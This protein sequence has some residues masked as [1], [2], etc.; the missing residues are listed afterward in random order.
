M[1]K[2][3]IDQLT[4]QHLFPMTLMLEYRANLLDDHLTTTISTLLKE[5]LIKQAELVKEEIPLS[6]ILNH[7]IEITDLEHWK[8]GTLTPP[9]RRIAV[10]QYIKAS[11]SNL[12]QNKELSKIHELNQFVFVNRFEAYA[13]YYPDQR[14]ILFKEQTWTYAEVN[15]RA[16]E[17]ANFLLKQKEAIELNASGEFIIGTFLPRTP[18]WIIAILAIW[19]AGGA[20]IA[21][22]PT[23][24]GNSPDAIDEYFEK[25]SQTLSD[26]KPAVI[27]THSDHQYLLPKHEQHNIRYLCLDEYE[28]QISEWSDE[29]IDIDIN[30]EELAYILYTSGSSGKPKGVEIAHRGFLPCLEAHRECVD[31]TRDS[32]MAQYATCDFDAWV[33][34]MMILGIGGTLAI[35]PSE[36][37]LD[38]KLCAQYYQKHKINVVIFT[39]AFL[40]KLGGPENFPFWRALFIVGE[41]FDWELVKKWKTEKLQ[42]V[43][44]YGLTETTICATLEN[45]DM[46]EVGKP[47]S[48]G[49]PIIGTKIIVKTPTNIDTNNLEIEKDY[50]PETTYYNAELSHSV[51][52]QAG[53]PWFGGIS[54]TRGYRGKAKN[55]NQW[56]FVEI[57]GERFY[58]S[59]DKA[60]LRADGRLEHQGR[61]S[62]M[63]KIS[64]KRIELPSIELNLCEKFQ[65]EKMQVA[66]TAV[67]N[68]VDDKNLTT[69][70]VFL[71]ENDHQK[72]QEDEIRNFIINTE[73]NIDKQTPLK[74]IW[75][76][77]FP[78]TQTKIN[79]VEL[80]KSYF[81]SVNRKLG[82]DFSTHDQISSKEMDIF[83]KLK[84]AWQEVI[85]V[86]SCRPEDDFFQIGGRSIDISPLIQAIRHTFPEIKDEVKMSLVIECKTLLS[87]TKRLYSL[88]H[89]IQLI[90]LNKKQTIDA[91]YIVFCPPSI[92]GDPEQDYSVL[93][94]QC[95]EGLKKPFFDERFQIYGLKARGLT[96]P[97]LM[98]RTLYSS[99]Q[100]YALTIKHWVIKNNKAEVPLFILGWSSGGTITPEIV[101][102]LSKYNINAYAYVIDSIAPFPFHHFNHEE[103]KLELAFLAGKLSQALGIKIDTHELR[104]ELSKIQKARDRIIHSFEY[105]MKNTKESFRNILKTAMIT[106]L[107][108]H[109]YIIYEE[110]PCIRLYT[111]SHYLLE[112]I[113]PRDKTHYWPKKCIVDPS[114]QED[115]L[116]ESDHFS[117]IHQPTLSHKIVTHI[118]E[119]FA[120]HKIKNLEKALYRN[121][122]FVAPLIE[123]IDHNNNEEENENERDILFAEAITDFFYNDQKSVLL[124]QGESGIGKSI[125]TSILEISLQRINVSCKTIILNRF[126]C[127]E[128]KNHIREELKDWPLQ[129]NEIRVLILEGYDERRGTTDFNYYV[130]NRL[131]EYQNLKVI[132]TCRSESLKQGY[133]TNFIPGE[134]DAFEEFKLQS[135][136]ESQIKALMS[137]RLKKTNKKVDISEIEKL[138]HEISSRPELLELVRNPL[139]LTFVVKSLPILM[140][141]TT[142]LTRFKIYEAFNRGYFERGEYKVKAQSG[143]D[144]DQDFQMECRLHCQKIALAFFSDGITSYEV[145]QNK[146]TS[147]LSIK[148]KASTIFDS[149]FDKSIK[150]ILK[151]SPIKNQNNLYQFTH[152]TE[153]DFFVVDA[154][155]SILKEDNANFDDFQTWFLDNKLIPEKLVRN[156]SFVKFWEDGYK[157]DPFIKTI[158]FRIIEAT[159]HSENLGKI[160]GIAMT[161]LNLASE[162]FNSANLSR[163]RAPGAILIGGYFDCTDFTA[164]DLRGVKFD[165]AWLRQTRLINCQ[166]TDVTFG[167]YPYFEYTGQLRSMIYRPDINRLITLVETTVYIWDIINRECIR[168]LNN[169]NEKH[170]WCMHLS[171]NGNKLAL[172]IDNKIKVYDLISDKFTILQGH[173]KTVWSVR[174]SEDGNMLASGSADKTV[175]VWFLL[176]N[177]KTVVMQGH[178][179]I[180]SAVRLSDDGR[181]VIS[182]SYMND[183]RS[184]DDTVRVWDVA[185]RQSKVLEANHR[186]GRGLYISGDGKIAV[187]ASFDHLIHIWNAQTGVIITTLKGHKSFVTSVALSNDLKTLVSSD[188]NTLRVWNVSSGQAKVLMRNDFGFKD[189]QLSKDELTVAASARST[190]RIWD[191]STAQEEVLR[192]HK[193]L[194]GSVDL[195]RNGQL[196]ASVG[197]NVLIED[198]IIRLWDLINNKS[199]VLNK[200][201]LSDS[202]PIYL[203]KDGRIA[204]TSARKN[205]VGVWDVSSRQQIF[206]GNH[207]DSLRALHNSSD[208]NTVVTSGGSQFGKADYSVKVWTVATG[209]VTILT[210]HEN[211]IRTVYLSGDGSVVASGSFDN[212]IRIWTVSSGKALVLRI[213]G[214]IKHILL[215]ENGKKIAAVTSKEVNENRKYTVCVWDVLTTKILYQAVADHEMVILHLNNNGKIVIATRKDER[216][217]IWDTNAQNLLGDFLF[218]SSVESISIDESFS[219]LAV[220]LR[221]STIQ[222]WDRTVQQNPEWK[223]RWSSNHPNLSLHLAD[224]DFSGSQGLSLQN[225]HLMTQR[226]AWDSIKGK[227][228]NSIEGWDKFSLIPDM[229]QKSK[230][231]ELSDDEDFSPDIAEF[232]SLNMN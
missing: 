148:K 80:Q 42:I 87:Q 35:V 195:S 216:L 105:L 102:A 27:I 162:S 31:L 141:Y 61:Y 66:V 82:F 67:G 56:R 117:I 180:V 129:S 55:Q 156:E 75:K 143:L 114:Q 38:E 186:G 218:N 103:H 154:I 83:T 3:L 57:D 70:L 198:N 88:L 172:A 131:S 147:L 140:N 119:D 189:V 101:N 152:K 123:I 48:I 73:K 226:G 39:P 84:K 76:S 60:I 203:S 72:K 2:E 193:C 127:E 212:T 138:Y 220:G 20:F 187:S 79:L 224:C 52:D 120:H 90:T 207:G 219:I 157:Q 26:A 33:A 104:S 65:L 213:D 208:R 122:N 15:A 99:A 32:I 214:S 184:Y 192:G 91:P 34:E 125:S 163:V 217:K 29:N 176:N 41:S 183:D 132:F 173:Q 160:G 69:V 109:N 14:A 113:L 171:G 177:R 231:S 19:K 174:L 8:N 150:S 45:L 59:G 16:N 196:I 28:E 121:P 225:Q 170:V 5:N 135:F 133:L 199:I 161:L 126:T 175:R 11:L 194:I 167:E 211:E 94:A 178:K 17:L 136:N 128:L 50:G 63:V 12:A 146:K 13:K 25:F 81:E 96:D 200:H 185:S 23:S 210:G 188:D 197:G 166:L 1:Y 134:R 97:S 222:V 115:T 98:P 164:S 221:D 74:I 46:D 159:R 124:L 58:K 30:P 205:T 100:D 202:L 9:K 86:E 62:R 24:I 53:E 4:K 181:T 21:I 51:F 116:I 168:E 85:S 201:R 206:L 89:P 190:V 191:I 78:T 77:E 230:K 169:E 153:I 95:D 7:P 22:D 18:E 204:A 93:L 68:S 40:N 179:K 227:K 158:L 110:I 71:V 37:R 145:N 223:L 137:I 64:G 107:A 112:G 151:A 108:E 54:L 155:I 142:T 49:K 215:S 43:N 228:P 149:L 92:L 182:G 6:I 118:I 209:Q 10:D 36:I 106:R 232:S 111:A 130:T 139:L 165:R 44:G 229:T 47:L 144:E